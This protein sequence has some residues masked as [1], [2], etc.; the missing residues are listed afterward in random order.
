MSPVF[1]GPT[2]KQSATLA[3]VY[4]ILGGL[5]FTAMNTL[6][7]SLGNTFAWQIIAF[8][9]TGLAFVFAIVLARS[10][11][12][13][14][15]VF[16]PL[17]LWIRSLAGSVSLVCCFF[18][19]TRGGPVAN[20]LAITNIFPIWVALLGWPMLGIKPGWSVLVSVVTAVAGVFLIRAPQIDG[21][22]VLFGPPDETT[23][24]ALFAFLASFATAVAMLGLNRLQHIDTRAVV[25][26][27]S[28][29]AMAVCVG[30]IVLDGVD[31][32]WQQLAEPDLLAMLLGVGV[33]AT[34]GQLCLTKAFTIGVPSKVSVVGLTQIVFTL[35]VDV[36]LFGVQFTAWNLAG[37]ALVLLPTAWVMLQGANRTAAVRR[38]AAQT[39]AHGRA[40]VGLVDSGFRAAP[41]TAPSR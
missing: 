31:I 12:A 3:Y 16:R 24:A 23:L 28:G 1:E 4:M 19:L 13:D 33:T 11:G 17:S 38:A 14:L 35:I 6:V 30:A 21:D 25:A 36:L 26:H 39:A 34:M 37:I 2:V 20:V 7:H 15:V 18:A 32:P 22:G 27:F 10:V 41:A 29:V 9:R 8:F 40:P 5:A